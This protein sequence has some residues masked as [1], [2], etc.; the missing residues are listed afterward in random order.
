MWIEYTFWD[1]HINEKQQYPELSTSRTSAGEDP[2][3]IRLKY[4]R[5]NG[6]SLQKFLCF[7]HGYFATI[8]L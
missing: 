2:Q 1:K 3:K 7:D 4:G 5:C 6:A 8:T